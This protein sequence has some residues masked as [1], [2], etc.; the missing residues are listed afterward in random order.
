M[1]I[2]KYRIIGDIHG[3][4]N[5]QQL[6]E[7]FDENTMYVFLGDFTDPYYGWEKVTYEQMIEQIKLMFTFKSEHPDNVIILYGNHDLQYCVGEGET[8]R[9]EWRQDRRETL[10]NLFKNNE[11]LFGGV[12][13][14]VGEKYLITH[15][16]VTYDWYTRYC[17][18]DVENLG[19][20]PLGEICKHINKVWETNK[21]AF[22]FRANA[23]KMSDYYGTDSHHSPIWVRPDTL[24]ENNLFGFGD[25]VIQIIGH[26][27]LDD[28]NDVKHETINRIGTYGT[29]KRPATEDELEGNYLLDGTDI[30]C[31]KINDP[32]CVNIILADCLRRETACVDIDVETL[33][34]SKY[35][36][37][38]DVMDAKNLI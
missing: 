4:E 29:F 24:W 38:E 15:A 10:F 7:P 3:R 30:C 14:H 17:D 27:P 1:E 2:K 11:E 18:Y 23:M 13:C 26:T 20:E 6:V 32:T 8:N 12:A 28:Y 16:G 31:L 19:K 34:W 33:E 5:W 22:T 25:R 37:G 21:A 35:K 36:V 9:Y